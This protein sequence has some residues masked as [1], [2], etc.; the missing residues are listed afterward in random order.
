MPMK[1][2]LKHMAEYSTLRIT[3]LVLNLLPYRASLAFALVPAW[4]AHYV[5][6]FRRAEAMRRIKSV[7]GNKYT[8]RQVARIAW[9]SWRNIIFN[10]V[11]ILRIPK[12]GRS[13]VESHYEA[14]KFLD[15]LAAH[16]KTGKGAIIATPHMGNWD[17]AALACYHRKIPF[18]SIAA[19]QRNQLVNDYFNRIR[20]LPGSETLTRGRSMMKQV[21]DNIRGS[22][23]LV[24]LPDSRMHEPDIEIDF[25]GKKA[26]LGKGMAFFARKTDSPIF[27]CICTRAGWTKHRIKYIDPVYPDNNLDKR[28]DIMRMTTGVVKALEEAILKE[29]EQWFWY[30]KRWV[31]DPPEKKGDEA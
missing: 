12:T 9:I 1:Y 25:L 15:A 27:P 14:D 16:V 13:W 30:N 2:K 3:A 29:P 4:I 24:I 6:Q 28:E 19:Q 5:F 22:R 8:D 11:E 23:M 10:F 26:N 17:L 20:S 18:F 31:L 21:V 7:F